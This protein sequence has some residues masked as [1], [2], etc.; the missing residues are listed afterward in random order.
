MGWMDITRTALGLFVL[1]VIFYAWVIEP[2][3]IRV[4]RQ[5]I[6]IDRLPSSL[7]GFTICHLSDL[8]IARVGRAE[9]ILKSILSGMQA[10]MCVISGDMLA[11]SA[12]IEGL[13]WAL[14]K[15]RPRYGIFGVVGNGEYDPGMP[16]VDSLA[17]GLEES[18][19][20]V[21]LNEAKAIEIENA[22]LNLIGVDDPFTGHDDLAKAMRDAGE[23]VRVLLA[24]SPD[25]VRKLDGYDIDLILTGHTHGGQIRLPLLGV[26]WTHCRVH[27]PK[28]AGYFSKEMVRS[29]GGDKRIKAQMYISRGISGSG[30]RARFLCSPEISLITLTCA[31]PGNVNGFGS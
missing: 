7:N 3:R 31:G 21:L 26:L 17:H 5:T 12:G 4:S 24:H 23:G 15:F 22:K 29:M 11:H 2:C 1:G 6:E 19:V 30:I 10:D 18:G 25:I 9:R 28:P 16:S 13:R 14:E 27:L 8:H 20:H